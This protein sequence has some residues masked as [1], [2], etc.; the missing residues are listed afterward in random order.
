MH[1]AIQVNV[2]YTVKTRRKMSG[3]AEHNH[4]EVNNMYIY[5]YIRLM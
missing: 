1:S 3:V 2:Q 4:K 5:I